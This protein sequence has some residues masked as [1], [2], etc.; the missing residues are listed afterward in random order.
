MYEKAK[1]KIG[2]SAH[3][4]RFIKESHPQ[5]QI[6]LQDWKN[7]VSE[8]VHHSWAQQNHPAS[9]DNWKNYETAWELLVKRFSNTRLT[10]S[11]LLDRI[12]DKPR[13]QEESAEKLKKLHDTRIKECLEGWKNLD[14]QTE[15]WGPILIRIISQKLGTERA[16]VKQPA[17]YAKI[18][19]SDGFSTDKISISR[20]NTVNKKVNAQFNK[21]ETISNT[22][23]CKYCRFS[24][25]LRMSWLPS[26]IARQID[27]H[28]L[29]KLRKLSYQSPI[30][31]QNKIHWHSKKRHRYQ[32]HPNNLGRWW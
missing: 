10:V 7:A 31:D 32:S 11:K 12:L 28:K 1:E 20:I 30:Q 18:R 9:P 23:L 22:K 2:R 3:F 13:I 16:V 24:F 6:A 8:D 25:N 17:R 4:P 15:T 19:E 29:H 21:M 27:I 26:R 14:M 5:Q